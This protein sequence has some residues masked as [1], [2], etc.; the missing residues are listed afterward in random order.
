MNNIY[1]V[2]A[3]VN[4]LKNKINDSYQMIH[5]TLL[6]ETEDFQKKFN[7]FKENKFLKIQQ[8]INKISL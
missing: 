3:N 5:K 7:K 6:N 2:Q 1:E 8:N 4:T